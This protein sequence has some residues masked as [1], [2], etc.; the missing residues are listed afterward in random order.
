MEQGGSG[1]LKIEVEE[2]S[3]VNG[4]PARYHRFSVKIAPTRYREY[5]YT[6]NEF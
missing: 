5:V 1:N 3:V 2:V 4:E 6:G